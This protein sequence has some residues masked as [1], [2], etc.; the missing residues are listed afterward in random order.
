MTIVFSSFTLPCS[1]PDIGSFVPAPCRVGLCGFS[2]NTTAYHRTA[3]PTSFGVRSTAFNGPH[4]PLFFPSSFNELR[5]SSPFFALPGWSLIPYSMRFSAKCVS[6][7]PVCSAFF[8]FL[9]LTHASAK[10]PRP[11][12]VRRFPPF[13][14]NLVS[15]V[16]KFSLSAVHS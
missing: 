15:F 9:S 12:S 16:E 7:N 3:W 5:R 8:F 1:S 14:A 10:S 13:P 6:S 11:D 4:S 2:F